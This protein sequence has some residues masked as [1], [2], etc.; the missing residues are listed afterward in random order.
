MCNLDGEDDDV[1]VIGQSSFE[2]LQTRQVHVG[3]V[4]D[5]PD[6]AIKKGRRCYVVLC[7]LHARTQARDPYIFDGPLEHLHVAVDPCQQLV[8]LERGQGVDRACGL[9]GGVKVGGRGGLGV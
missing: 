5:T 4:E 1:V 2:I 9:E 8:V 7:F 6:V 3:A